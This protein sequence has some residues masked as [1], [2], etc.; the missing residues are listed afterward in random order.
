MGSF[1]K[2]FAL[3]TFVALFAIILQAY[4]ESGSLQ[5]LTEILTSLIRL[6]K[7]NS[8]NEVT[9]KIAIGFG[10]CS[11]LTVKA[12]FLNFS[13]FNTDFSKFTE[14]N[15]EINTYEDFM[16]SFYFYFSKSAAAERYTGNKVLFQVR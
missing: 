3:A 10:C 15:D 9:K 11:D 13:N 8:V 12:N 4:R 2:Y 1:F 6:E 7:V 5:D 14:S 16:R